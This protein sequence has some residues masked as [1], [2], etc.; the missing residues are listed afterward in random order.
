MA[1]AEDNDIDVFGKIDMY[2]IRRHLRLKR[3]P[4]AGVTGVGDGVRP[5]G[6]EPWLHLGNLLTLSVPQFHHL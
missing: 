1:R 5:L 3:Q 6:I 2:Q 4:R